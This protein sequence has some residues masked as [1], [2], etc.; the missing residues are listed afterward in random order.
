ML[1]SFLGVAN[2]LQAYET[3]ELSRM[4]RAGAGELL[5]LEDN[6]LYGAHDDECYFS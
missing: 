5:T 3:G 6:I 2:M 1:G 4:P